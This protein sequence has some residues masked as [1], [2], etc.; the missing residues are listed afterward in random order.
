[1]VDYQREGELTMRTDEQVWADIVNE[2]RIVNSGVRSGVIIRKDAELK[3]L[4][5]AIDWAQRNMRYRLLDNC[6]DRSIANF[7]DELVHEA[8]GEPGR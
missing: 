5:G 3:R 1:V 6:T 8:K 4:W 2:C 7:L